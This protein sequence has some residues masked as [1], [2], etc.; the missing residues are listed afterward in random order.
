MAFHSVLAGIGRRLPIIGDIIESVDPLEGLDPSSFDVGQEQFA[1][2]QRQAL[3]QLQ[4]L[5]ELRSVAP[6]SVPGGF[7]LD[8]GDDDPGGFGFIPQQPF[9]PPSL[10][11]ALQ[12]FAP[13]QQSFAPPPPQDSVASPDDFLDDFI[14]DFLARRKLRPG[15]G[16]TGFGRL[17]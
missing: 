12:P 16:Q 5:P 14:P 6:A 10:T 2:V 7:Q 13:P 4:G 15:I 11:G 17:L 9:I 8:F 3:A 1:E